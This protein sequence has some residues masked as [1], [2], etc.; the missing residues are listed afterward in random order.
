MS[1]SDISLAGGHGDSCTCGRC[2]TFGGYGVTTARHFASPNVRSKAITP[3]MRRRAALAQARR[4][5][6]H[7]P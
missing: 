4:A 3:R 2:A 5:R 7:N 1:H 6:K